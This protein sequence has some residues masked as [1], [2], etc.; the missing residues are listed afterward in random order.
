[1]F[2]EN[3]NIKYLHR[4]ILLHEKFQL[5]IPLLHRL[6]NSQY[7]S[8]TSKE[9]DSEYLAWFQDIETQKNH[10]IEVFWSYGWQE[11]QISFS[12]LE[13]G[14]LTS[15]HYDQVARKGDIQSCLCTV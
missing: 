2:T 10:V 5:Q 4:H 12:Y 14:I 13:T 1:M 11:S 3:D 6:I 8:F 15:H 7:I 9:E